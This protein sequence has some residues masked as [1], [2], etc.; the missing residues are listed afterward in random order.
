MKVKYS[1]NDLWLWI[2]LETGGLDP[3]IC[4]ILEIAAIVTD[5][6]FK[7]L[8]TFEQAVATDGSE[9]EALK[10]RMMLK[11]EGNRRL[12]SNQTLYD[13]H[14]ASGLI[15]KIAS[16]TRNESQTE[17][18]FI[19]FIDRYFDEGKIY[20]A[21][22]SIHLDRRFIIQRW[23]TI[24]R[25]LHYRMLDVTSYKILLTRLGVTAPVKK[26]VHRAL[27]DVRSSIEEMSCYL[28]YFHLLKKI[29]D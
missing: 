29:A 15:D 8:D 16:A 26:D 23:P 24:E 6:N 7:E 27:D 20:I 4:P 9:I 18:D 12:P 14:K 21:G 19:R 2:D 25:R 13:V 17:K 10:G 5:N 3:V 28:K 11:W 1:V 22:N